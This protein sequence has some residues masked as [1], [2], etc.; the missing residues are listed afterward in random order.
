[1][2]DKL[3]KEGNMIFD[4]FSTPLRIDNLNRNVH[5]HEAE[6]LEKLIGI[7]K[8]NLGNE[9]SASSNVLDHPLLSELAFSCTESLNNFAREELKIVQTSFRI[10]QS[11]VNVSYKNGYHFAHSHPNSVFSGVLYLQAS[12]PDQIMFHRHRE[13]TSWRFAYDEWNGYN[14]KT[15]TVPVKTGDIVIF[16]SQLVHEVPLIQNKK[17]VSLAFNS[18]PVGTF[19]MEQESTLVE[20]R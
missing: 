14:S 11:W 19:G 10:T 8:N 9:R 3:L 2:L 12:E 6:T 7:T 20:M 16:P 5:P 4:L 1:M 18:F 13:E 17:R 15:W